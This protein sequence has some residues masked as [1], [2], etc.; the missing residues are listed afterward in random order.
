M[1]HQVE[2]GLLIIR[3]GDETDPNRIVEVLTQA[4][5]SARLDPSITDRIRM[6]WDATLA[7]AQADAGK[8]QDMLRRL[9]GES[10]PVSKMAFVVDSKLQFGKGR[11]FGAYADDAGLDVNV[12][13][14]EDEARRWLLASVS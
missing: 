8:M 6:L 3:Q 10:G 1:S 4:F 12:F 2:S 9:G 5:L 13:F 11:M 7:P 14:D